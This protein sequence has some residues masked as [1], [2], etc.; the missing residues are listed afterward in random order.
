MQLH[1]IFRQS[2]MCNDT[3]V[4]D[5]FLWKLRETAINPAQFVPLLSKKPEG[6]CARWAPNKDCMWEVPGEGESVYRSEGHP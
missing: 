1:K 5:Y 3:E 4:E 2:G 6:V